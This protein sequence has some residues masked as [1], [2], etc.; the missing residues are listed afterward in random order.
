[1]TIGELKA[2]YGEDTEIYAFNELLQETEELY[3]SDI[4]E[5]EPG[6]III[7]KLY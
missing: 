2:R 5:L 6:K 4:Q 1:M 3:P 7:G